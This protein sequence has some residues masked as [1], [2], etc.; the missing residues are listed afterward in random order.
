MSFERKELGKGIYLN[1][2]R[3]EK[4]KASLISLRFVVPL[5]LQTAA[6]NALLFPVL[7]RGCERYPD[8]GRIRKEEESIYDTN[9]SDSVYKRGDLQILELRMS[10]L[11]NQYAIDGMNI[12]ERAV[13]LLEELLFHPV[14]MWRAKRKSL[15]MISARR[16]MT[17]VGTP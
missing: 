12:T 3:E 9:I 2:V 13:S 15:L 8:I 10:L 11:D 16:S 7:L 4:F 17:S 5:A 6:K 14:I 1:T